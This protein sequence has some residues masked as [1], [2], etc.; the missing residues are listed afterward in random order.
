MKLVISLNL[1]IISFLIC[2]NPANG[3]ITI[4]NKVQTNSTPPS[5]L[6]VN[7]SIPE[8]SKQSVN[9]PIGIDWKPMFDG[10]SLAGWKIT[11][12]PGHSNVLVKEHLIILEAGN[13]LTG[14]TWTN[15][16]PKMNYEVIIDAA[17]LDSSDFFCGI[18]FPVGDSYC[19][20]IPGGWGGH[21][22]GISSINGSD[23]SQ[24]ETTKSMS[25]K[26]DRFYRFKIKVTEE[27][28]EA[29]IDNIK[30][31]DLVYKDRMLSTRLEMEY[32]K[33]FGIASWRT[34]GA[35]SN[36]WFRIIK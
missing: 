12:F 21:V 24:N 11:E 9:S 4:T 2:I 25:F 6:T 29:W 5:A 27:K 7:T 34:T 8:T 16:F 13:D 32:S 15:P 26:K 35:I 23:A 1:I 28:I 31:V 33:P 36:I 30:F 18:T 17:R 19:S 10:S 20:F 22:V 14:I 3:E